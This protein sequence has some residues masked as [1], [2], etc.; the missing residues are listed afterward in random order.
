M[1]HNFSV[2]REGDAMHKGLEKLKEIRERLKMR[3]WTTLPASSTPSVSSVWSWI[4]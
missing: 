4:T 3:A 1:Q 2:F